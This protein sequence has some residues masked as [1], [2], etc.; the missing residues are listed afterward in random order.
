MRLGGID[1]KRVIGKKFKLGDLRIYLI[2][3]AADIA[4]AQC[5]N[6]SRCV[7]AQT[8]RRQ[9]DLGG[10]GLVEVDANGM[11]VSKDGFRYFY[12]CGHSPIG[13]LRRFDILGEERGLDI[14]RELTKE[15]AF[16]YTLV[17]VSPV[18]K[19]KSREEQD[20]INRRRRERDA[21][22]RAK[23]NYTRKHKRYTGV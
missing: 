10:Q 7:L 13:F 23:G 6:R 19:P 22:K 5:G 11:R 12:T 21:D 20:E 17:S 1:P 2:V 9:F 14:A 4:L 3:T 8:V 18:V 16:I 15:R